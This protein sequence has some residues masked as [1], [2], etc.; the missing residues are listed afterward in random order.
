MTQAASTLTV[1]LP[2]PHAAQQRVITESVRFNVVCCGRRFG[3]TVLGI[4][5]LVGP[6]IMEHRPTAWFSPTYKM[7]SDTW[8]EVRRTLVAVTER[9]SEAEHRLELVGG[10]SVEMWSLDSPDSARGRRY[11]RVIIDEAA[12][13][14]ALQEAWEAV[15]RPTLS[16]FRGDAYFLSTP[17]GYNYFH[18]LYARGLDVAQ[19]DWMSWQM[20]TSENPHISPEE[21]ESARRDLPGNLFSQEYLARFEALA[22]ARFDLDVVNESLAMCRPEASIALPDGCKGARVWASPRPGVP[23]VAYT[24]SAEGKGQDYTVTVILEARTLKH[25]CTLRENELEPGQHA[26]VAEKLCRWY[27]TALWGVERNRGEAVLY[28]VGQTK[29]PRVYWHEEGSQTMAQRMN[30]TRPTQRL[31]FPV[32]E[33]TR[34]GLIDDLAEA[35]ANRSLQSDDGV[36]WRECQSFVYNERGRP[37]A[38]ENMHDDCVMAM[39]GCVR[40]ARQPGAQAMVS[41]VVDV[42]PV[43]YGWGR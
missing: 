22:A 30:G 14:K 21:I 34:I 10:G 8:R 6:A 9:V 16:D 25:V 36:F 39:A 42:G 17:R 2:R 7:L 11:A 40:M 1:A 3:K 41:Q 4:D 27:N 29:Y 26:M 43:T 20:P 15:I 19:T 31:G 38:A 32:T 18:E 35:I 23:Y 33:N 13:V 24:D 5:R 37:E 12:T 28:V